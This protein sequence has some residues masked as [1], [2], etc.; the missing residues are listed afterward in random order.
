MRM[1][2]A[3]FAILLLLMLALTAGAAERTVLMEGFSNTS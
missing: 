1:K 3:P 2:R